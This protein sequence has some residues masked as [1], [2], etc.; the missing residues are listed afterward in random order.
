MS[1][2]SSL[3]QEEISK[4]RS[5]AEAAKQRETKRPKKTQNVEVEPVSESESQSAEEKSDTAPAVLPEEGIIS[6]EADVSEPPVIDEPIVAPIVIAEKHTPEKDEI[7]EAP[8]QQKDDPLEITIESEDIAKDINKV[9]LQIRAYLKQILNGWPTATE[10]EE[11]T[12]IE[13]KRWIVPLLVLLKRGTL[14]I[15]MAIS[16]CTIAQNLQRNEYMKANENYIKLSIGSIAWPIGVMNVGIHAR[17]ADD[18]IK[19]KEGHVSN[20]MKDDK[21]RHWLLALKRIITHEESKEVKESPG[22]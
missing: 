11:L 14:P 22:V 16:V 10:A 19:G 6:G 4:K 9:M 3:L 1:S 17:S 2:F 21:T 12:L 7:I 8:K 13:T 18:K 5:Q 20:I 15:E